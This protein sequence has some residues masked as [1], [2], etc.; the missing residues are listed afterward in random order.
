MIIVI[1]ASILI[2]YIYEDSDSL[3][4][5][6]D[7]LTIC[8]N[9]QYSIKVDISHG[10]LMVRPW[11]GTDSTGWLFLNAPLIY[12]HDSSIIDGSESGYRGGNIPHPDGY[13]PG[14][15]E[16]GGGNGGGGGGAGYGGDGGNG[17]DSYPGSGGSVYG[18]DS[19]TLI[20]MGSGGGAGRLSAVD[21][22]G[23]NGGAKVYLRGQKIVVDTSE[24]HTNGQSGYDGSIEA[25]GGGSGGGIMIW[26]DSIL[27]HSSTLNSNGGNGGDA[28]FGGGGGAGG[29]RI[30]IFHSPYLDTSEMTLSV[31]Q[32]TA[33][34]GS[35]GNPAPGMP[36]STYIGP[37][38]GITEIA[39]NAEIGL[40]IHSNPVRR[41]IKITPENTP[42]FLRLYDISGRVV[43]MFW[44]RNR[45]EYIC[46]DDLSQGIYFLKSGKENKSIGKIILLK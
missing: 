11:D 20:D 42:I 8:G 33:G 40:K 5:I 36:G 25:G 27:I 10:K 15:G 12:L 14:Y 2:G 45:T 29:G 23:G 31:L 16:G 1:L 17:G 44:I 9:H 4:V 3:I 18:D 37:I 19:D 39:H 13:G 22:F 34:S 41:G 46:L 28:S 21:G 35:Y 30:K 24:I 43:K 7:S 38:I 6:D 32:G 26:A